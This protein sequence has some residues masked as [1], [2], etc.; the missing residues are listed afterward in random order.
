LK[1]LIA[2]EAAKTQ[3]IQESASGP[4]GLV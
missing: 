2:C 1:P 3:V 4:G